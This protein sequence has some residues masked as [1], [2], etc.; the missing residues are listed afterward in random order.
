VADT[1][2]PRRK[3]RAK[4]PFKDNLTRLMEEKKLGVRE[5]AE[6]S[7]ISRS[8]IV[9]WRAG[10]SPTD[11]IAVRK[12]AEVLGVSF[13]WANYFRYGNSNR[14]FYREVKSVKRAVWH[15][16]RRK[17]RQQRRP[18]PWKRLIP[19]GLWI[20]RGIRPVRVIPDS[21]R[22]SQSQMSFA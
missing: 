22:Q 19:L 15:Y 12:L 5:L 8:T 6:K 1:G 7:G 16:L 3:P 11:F 20:T 2:A 10:A 14:V 4:A 9:D 18:V 17:N 21:L 13:R